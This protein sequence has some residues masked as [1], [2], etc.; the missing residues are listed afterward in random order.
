MREY[1]L[2][3]LLLAIPTM[4]LVSMVVFGLIRLIPGDIAVLMVEDFRYASDVEELRKR[5]GLD[6]PLPVQYAKWLWQ[7]LQGDLG[8]SLWTRRT[9]ME[10]V[11]LRFPVS[12]ELGV[13]AMII[14]LSIALPIGVLSA[15]R[16][17]TWADYI[18]RT[19]A[20]IGLSM[21]N[22]WIATLVILFGSTLWNYSPALQFIPFTQDP[23]RNLGQFIPPAAILGAATAAVTMRMTRGMML[24]VLRQDYIRTAW[25][26]GLRERVVIY[27]HA[28][29][30]ALVPVIT[31]IGLQI[32]VVLSGTVILETIFGL[33]GMSRF[34]L[35]AIQNRDYP[36]LQT[37]NLLY[38]AVV[39][40][41]NL[42]VDILYGFL[43]PRIRYR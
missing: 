33:P 28:L 12:V 4:L 31:I 40:L 43:D 37:V 34:V 39:V 16:Q 9:A 25:A 42:V 36:M 14:S 6:Q 20:I 5:L 3:R 26:K 7:I 32:P 29:R 21:P 8:E 24:E 10:E 11:L 30:N 17:D 1:I 22:F 2:R 23:L 19:L 27:R 35:N 13:L 15:I 18:A 41:A 38:A